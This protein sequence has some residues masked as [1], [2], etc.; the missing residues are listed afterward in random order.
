MRCDWT[1]EGPEEADSRAGPS[2]PALAAPA[3]AG[4][5]VWTRPGSPAGPSEK[6]RWR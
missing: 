1:A 2:L 3:L 5:G 4:A 6:R